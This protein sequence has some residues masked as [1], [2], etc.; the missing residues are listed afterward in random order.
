MKRSQTITIAL[1]VAALTV[2]LVPGFA[3]ELLTF[4][5][6]SFT[7]SVNNQTIGWSFAVNTAIQVSD[8]SWYDPVGNNPVDHPVAIWNS[9]G[10]IVAS[11]CVG[12]GCGSSYL[13]PFSISSVTAN[14]VPGNYVIGGYIL[15]NGSDSFVLGSPTIA[16]DP[17]IMCGQSLFL[18]SGSLT[19]PTQHCWGA[20]F[21]GPDLSSVPEPAT[22]TLA[23]LGLG[24]TAL[25]RRL[26]KHTE[27]AVSRDSASD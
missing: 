24:I 17:R 15:A 1:F 11:A 27:K 16:T 3:G 21:F 6:G 10:Q 13:A 14:L 26:Q 9:A 20:G 19:E 4:T 7:P 22:L 8:L 12:P 2:M 5:G 25:W 23:G 18:V